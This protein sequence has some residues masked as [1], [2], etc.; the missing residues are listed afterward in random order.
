MVE[1][2][3]AFYVSVKVDLT[4]IDESPFNIMVI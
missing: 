1:K 3:N 2:D 4:L